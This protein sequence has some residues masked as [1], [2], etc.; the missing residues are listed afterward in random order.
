MNG[1]TFTAAGITGKTGPTLSDFQS[2]YAGQGF[3]DGYFTSSNGIQLWYPPYDGV[4]EIEL[5][6]ASGGKNGINMNY[7][8][9]DPGQGA[10][11]IIRVTLSKSTQYSLVVGQKS[12]GEGSD[13][14]SAGG[15]GSWIYTGSIGGSG[16]IAC[17]G[18]GGGWGHGG[19]DTSG[20]N[21]LGGSATTSSRAVAKNTLINGKKGSGTGT[22]ASVGQGGGL[23]TEGGSGGSAGGAGWESDGTDRTSGSTAEG[24][25]SAGT[26]ASD[27]WL[28]GDS[29]RG[30]NCDGGFGG[31]GGANGNGVAGGG[32]GGYTGGSAANDYTSTDNGSSW[33]NGGG[34]GSYYD[35]TTTT[36]VSATAG[37]DGGEHLRADS[38][39]G[40]IKITF[41]G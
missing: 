16:L 26:G 8:P 32:G 1:F 37:A 6:G 10:L 27:A 31:G 20:G 23:A 40:Y 34:G 35:T 7:Y 19:S 21:G 39:N 29:N 2:A 9:A 28:G 14:G 24:G 25:H 3:L 11:M 13:A 15:G 18:G 33:G 22:A 36:L 17:A 4:Y 12:K 41:I 5:R 38:T 30:E